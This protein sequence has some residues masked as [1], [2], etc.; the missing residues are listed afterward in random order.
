MQEANQFGAPDERIGVSFAPLCGFAVQYW[1]SEAARLDS[2]DSGAFC[3]P[4]VRLP[5]TTL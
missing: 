5:I 3:A 2:R 4:V 1:A